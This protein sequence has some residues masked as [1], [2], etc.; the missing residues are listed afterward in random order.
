MRA[1]LVSDHSVRTKVIP[2]R[3]QQHVM[4]RTRYAAFVCDDYNPTVL[5]LQL[6]KN[7]QCGWTGPPR[8]WF[9]SGACY[10]TG[11]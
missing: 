11:E 5:Q 6:S 9:L 8:Q 2:C 10:V 4:L 3:L 1:W 7:M